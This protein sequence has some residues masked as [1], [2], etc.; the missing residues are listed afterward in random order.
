[1]PRYKE[2]SKA[3]VID[4]MLLK[5]PKEQ[6]SALVS[7]ELFERDYTRIEEI[8]REYKIQNRPELKDQTGIKKRIKSRIKGRR[9]STI[10]TR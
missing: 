4:K 8:I 3:F 1:M 2:K 7:D 6:L 10:K 9:K 5:V